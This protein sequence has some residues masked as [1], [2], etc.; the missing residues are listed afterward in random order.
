MMK[1]VESEGLIHKMGARSRELA[2][3]KYDVV[4]VNTALLS[5]MG[6]SH[7]TVA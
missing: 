1:F 4:D 6:L 7:E 5:L 2:V 3:E